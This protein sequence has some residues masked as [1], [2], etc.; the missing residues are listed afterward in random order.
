MFGVAGSPEEA[1]TAHTR[2]LSAKQLKLIK[3][4][5]GQSDVQ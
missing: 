5:R 3:W 4:I 2:I 1:K